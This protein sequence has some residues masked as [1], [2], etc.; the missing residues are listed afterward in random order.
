M[1]KIAELFPDMMDLM[2]DTYDFEKGIRN[3]II[4]ATE[5]KKKGNSIKGITIDSGNLYKRSVKARKCIG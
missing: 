5:L 4:V 3:A 1:R 2:V